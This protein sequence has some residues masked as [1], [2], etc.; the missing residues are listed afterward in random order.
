MGNAR[1]FR[2]AR[3]GDRKK[4]WRRSGLAVDAYLAVQADERAKRCAAVV[5]VQALLGFG[6]GE[7]MGRRCYVT[8]A[9]D[10]APAATE[11][12]GELRARQ[13]LSVC[14]S[15]NGA[16]CFGTNWA[17][18]MVDGVAVEIVADESVNREPVQCESVEQVAK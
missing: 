18:V 6:T 8:Y 12:I 14:H 10:K 16:A 3:P 2:A 17:R 4:Y 15:A 13:V 5:K 11:R 1:L 7:V 9:P